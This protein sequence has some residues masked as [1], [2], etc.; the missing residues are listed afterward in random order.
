MRR[1]PFLAGVV[2][3]LLVLYAGRMAI[4]KGEFPDRLVAPLLVPDTNGRADAI[5]VMG[6]GVV[7]PCTP[8]LNGMRRVLLA[9]RLW[10][11][12]R[13]PLLFFTGGRAPEG[14]ATAESMA[15]TAL[16]LGVP[17]SRIVEETRSRSTHENARFSAPLLRE[18]GI[19]RLLVVTDRLHMRR[20]SA[21]FEAMGFPV[22]R[23][24]VPIY[25]GHIN[26]VDMLASGVRE[27]AA[28][29]YYRVRG[30]LT[31]GVQPATPV[32][33]DAVT[34]E[35]MNADAL[36]HPDGPLVILGASYAG[37]W[38]LAT[39]DGR[40]VVNKGV[41]GEQSFEMAARFERD[42]VAARPRAVLIWGFINDIFRAP[43]GEMPATLDRV[44]ASYRAM[45]DA[46]RTAGIEPILAT[47]ITVRPPDSLTERLARLVGGLLGKESYQDRINRQ[48]A[49]INAWLAELATRERL[50]LLDFAGTLGD[51]DGRRRREFIADDGSHVP[52]AGYAALTDYATPRLAAHLT[53][54]GSRP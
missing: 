5:V 3:T 2:T 44:R 32:R 46:A 28:L 16:E 24:S 6:A 29:T 20:A 40:P 53:P 22:E 9:A 15:R 14:C 27:A 18:R 25:E 7:G 34:V 17:E 50:L 39:I 42:V 1:H 21:A 4:N 47:E 37:S 13:A 35:P 30:W 31:P 33:A 10:K 11:Q 43:A 49:E 36:R 54:R 23:A 19:R 26:N 45:I 52:P 51:P 8:N 38:P 48:V 12:G 41:A